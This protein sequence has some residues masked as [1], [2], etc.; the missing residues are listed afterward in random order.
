MKKVL[1]SLTALLCATMMS[2]QEKLD[3]TM[4]PLITFFVHCA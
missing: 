4:N 3:D 1:V 2:A